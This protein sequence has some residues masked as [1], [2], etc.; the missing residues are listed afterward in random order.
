VLFWLSAQ[1]R[2]FIKQN[3]Q[4][5]EDHCIIL[6]HL[7]KQISQSD[8]P[9][10]NLKTFLDIPNLTRPEARNIADFISTTNKLQ[11]QNRHCKSHPSICLFNYDFGDSRFGLLSDIHKIEKYFSIRNYQVQPFRYTQNYPARW[12]WFL[13]NKNSESNTRVLYFLESYIQA[14]LV[15]VKNDLWDR[16]IAASSIA[17]NAINN[18]NTQWWLYSNE[19]N[20][21]MII[22]SKEFFQDFD[23]KTNFIQT[24]E[25]LQT[26]ELFIEKITN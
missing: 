13:V 17:N 14:S 10:E 8:N 23:K 20:R 12:R 3:R 16:T 19:N 6:Y 11:E 1:D 15:D 21:D 24:R 18:P 4:V 2:H 7:I 22:G 25:W 26:P 5:L 9:I